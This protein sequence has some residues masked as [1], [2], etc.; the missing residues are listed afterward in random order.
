MSLWRLVKSSLCFYWRTNTGVFLAAVVATAILVGALLVGDSVRYSLKRLVTVR[1]GKVE[2]ALAGQN[3]FFRAELADDLAAELKAKVA[4]VLQLRGLAANSNG[5]R[6]ANRLEVLGVDER[7]YGLGTGKTPFE[8]DFHEGAILNKPLAQRLGTAI[9]DEIVLRI[10]K[11]GLMPRDVPLTPDSDSS[12]AFRL[13]V[14]AIA[15][16][17]EFGSF[18]LQANQVAP[19]NVF[20][21]LGWLQE[22]SSQRDNANM[23]LVG[24]PKADG[25]TVET[26]N[27][28]VKR[29]CKPADVGLELRR[30]EE[31]NAVEMRSR[32]IFID[33]FL[34]RA[35]ID[36]TEDAVGVLTY[37]VNEL[38][39]G[40]KTTPYSF[41]TAIGPV[42]NSS[43]LIP[44]D[45]QDDEILISRWLADDLGA[46][47]GDDISLSYFVVGPTRKLEERAGSFRVADIIP[48]DKAGDRK[49]M[50][51]F[52]G[53][54]D[55]INC[56][57]WKPGIPI[58][59]KKIRDKDDDKDEDYWDRYR[60]RPKAFVTLRAGQKMWGNRFGNLT[61]VRYPSGE[62]SEKNIAERLLKMVD[63][64][65]AGLYFQPVRARSLKAGREATDFGQLFLGLSMFLIASALILM[66]LVFVFGVEKRSEQVGMLLAVGFSPKL[67]RQL[68]LLEGAVLAVFGAAGGAAAGI[69]Y[70]R[71]MIYGLG[72]VWQGAVGG[73]AIHFNA[74]ASSIFYGVAGGVLVSFMAIWGALRKQLRQP[75]RELLSR[76]QAARPAVI[77]PRGKIGLWTAVAAIIGAVVLIAVMGN[78]KSGAFFGAAACL[79]IAEIGI[80]STLLQMIG[81]KWTKS[82]KSLAGL[83]L[84][85]S[86]RRR[87]RSLAVVGLLAAGSFL[88][89]AVG[90]NRKDPFADSHKR[91]SGTGGFALIGESSIGIL[92]DLNAGSERKSLGLNDGAPK[93]VDIVQL[94]VHDGDDA[95]CLNLNRAQNPRL[96][97]VQPRQLQQRGAF[98]FIETTGSG[99]A[100]DGWNLLKSE[101][102]QGVV[103][104]IGDYATVIW[105]IGKRLGDE[106]DYVDERGRKFRLRL[107]G[108]LKN[109]IL[110]G[111]LVIDSD[112][113]LRRFP[114]EDGYRMF[115]VDAPKT[116]VN[117]V[118]RRLSVGLQDF[119]LDLTPS[120]QRLVEFNKIENTY[121]SIFQLLGGLG[122]IL[123]S[124]GLGLVVLLNVLDRRGEMAMLQAVG[125][126]KKMLGQ[127]VLYEHGG[128]ML[129]GL[130][131][132]VVAAL[133]AIGPVLRSPRAEAPYLSL[134]ITIAAI[135]VSGIA[136]IWIAT[137]F[138]LSGRPLDA[139]RH[140]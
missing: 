2:L 17:S 105:A 131:C 37:F 41:V 43:S 73:S 108:L 48:T 122:L 52:P 24:S 26:A 67:V 134:A 80:A 94:R 140:E 78:E 53:L 119:G 9:G 39:L 110:Q 46:K 69:L 23:L 115:L 5:T 49:L 90:A 113:F 19:L 74:K 120:A 127:M 75:A 6:R 51:D 135:A 12:I 57:D 63:V 87:G 47:R 66:G 21:P 61:A 56:R 102:S 27:E 111:N 125:F 34:A 1:L 84:R 10:G 38:R 25:V 107:V 81:A 133:L 137:A 98:G 62:E 22:K 60:G 33:D 85:N 130:L 112:E 68:L 96:L 138:T 97:G 109:S 13:N 72:T 64:S 79:L 114:S 129:F 106:L 59:A 103:P 71:A 101:Q 16:G 70:T 86:T 92:R 50:P 136:W 88:V 139:L 11:P 83:G 123:G 76:I 32:R 42:E 117:E 55:E 124:V 121:L 8:G 58:D 4:P 15:D 126:D 31:H 100:V 7:F 77:G 35:A 18:S 118:S 91:D 29:R 14:E 95:S 104:A 20:V 28:A 40:K 65:S 54:A 3:R 45:M 116:Q 30:L 36:V 82:M 44:A 89:I 128:L 93:T 132:G 99:G